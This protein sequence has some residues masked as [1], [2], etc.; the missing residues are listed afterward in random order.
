[1]YLFFVFQSRDVRLHGRPTCPP[2]TDNLNQPSP[3]PTCTYCSLP[4]EATPFFAS[5]QKCIPRTPRNRFSD[6]KQ[7]YMVYSGPS[8]MNYGASLFLFES[9]TNQ[10][11]QQSLRLNK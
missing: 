10:H 5:T 4:N 11:T 2:P 3:T 1:M 8:L 6:E 7:F 9:F